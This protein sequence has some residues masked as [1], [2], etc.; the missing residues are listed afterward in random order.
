[1]SAPRESPSAIFTL[2]AGVLVAAAL[3]A[4]LR[5]SIPIWLGYLAGINLAAFALTGYDKAVAGGT[6]LRVP[7]AVLHGIALLGG[8]PAAFLAQRL[9]RH[10]T[11]KESFRR[12]F[13][14]IVALQIL[15]L[16]LAVWAWLRPPDWMPEG[17][18]RLLG[19][20]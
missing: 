18:R 13:R 7:E 3:Y 5:F 6:A 19:G 4:A 10:K 8:S 12:A 17:L 14:L 11:A 9:F 16:G 2:A 15:L 20:R 1:M